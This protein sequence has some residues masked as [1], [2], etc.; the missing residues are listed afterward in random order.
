MRRSDGANAHSSSDSRADF[1]QIRYEICAKFNRRKFRHPLITQGFVR[2]LRNH[3]QP[4]W[5][6]LPV[7]PLAL[8]TSF[9]RRV[10]LLVLLAVQRDKQPGQLTN[11]E[12][13]GFVLTF[14]KFDR[15]VKNSS[16]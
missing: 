11:V 3:F 13:Y 10:R 15:S 9:L 7:A 12:R 1:H 14:E 2:L 8:Y 4:L 6:G 5:I 16:T